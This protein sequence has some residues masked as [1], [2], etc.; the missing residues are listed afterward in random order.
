MF[1]DRIVNQTRIDLIQRKIDLPLEQIKQQALEQSR[2]RDVLEAFEPQGRVHL[3]AE[4]KRASPSKG[5]LAPDLDPVATAM[6]YE[7]N[8]ATVISVL[9]E[10]HFFL[11]SPDYLTAIKNAVSVPVLRKDFII[12]EYQIYEAR[13]WGADM[14]LLICAIL[15]DQQLRHLLQVATSLRMRALVEVHSQEEAR[16]AVAAGA[17]IIGVN[18]RNLTTFEM[19]PYLIRDIRR[20]LPGDRVIVAESGIHNAAD[21][22]RLARYDVQAMLVGES[23]VVSKDIPTQ[24]QMLLQ[25]ANHTTQVK[26]CG[27]REP[28]HINA[29]IDAGADMLG[30]IF[31]K[32]SHRYI[33]PE[34]VSEVLAA[35]QS[36]TQP[37]KGQVLPDLV[38]VF[39]NQDA[40]T[41]NAIADQIGLHYIQLHGNETPEFCQRIKRPVIKA[42]SLQQPADLARLA[43]Y[44]DVTWRLLIDTPTADWGGTGRTGDW[45][46]ARLAAQQSKILLAGGLTI[47]NVATAIRQVQPWGIDVS[48]GVETER[49]KDS[50]KIAAFIAQVRQ[51]ENNKQEL[52]EH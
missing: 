46:L 16:R 14:V 18:S 43:A 36:Y 13:A 32:P 15:D 49:R 33:Q 5:L 50:Q 45:E 19:N 48:S 21:V 23:L 17:V 10:P 11:G 3:I 47:E 8:G 51:S 2:T 25:H 41:I 24:I 31:H 29:A 22:R 4:V 34:R 27:L 9:T 35:S 1:L 26:I 37:R 28:E 20:T 39:V 44:R 40:D 7:Q 12:D 42:L 6:L 30:F 52:L 38:G